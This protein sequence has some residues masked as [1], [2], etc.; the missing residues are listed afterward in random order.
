MKDLWKRLSSVSLAA[1]LTLQLNGKAFALDAADAAAAAAETPPQIV[2]PALPPAGTSFEGLPSSVDPAPAQGETPAV[3]TADAVPTADAP[4]EKLSTAPD[5]APAQSENQT[6]AIQRVSLPADPDGTQSSNASE[7]P[8]LTDSSVGAGSPKDPDSTPQ[9][10]SIPVTLFAV[11]AKSVVQ[12]NA[13]GA[14]EQGQGQPS[15]P[16]AQQPDDQELPDTQAPALSVAGEAVDLSANSSGSGWKYDAQD[17]SLVLINFDGSAQSITTEASDI[18]I[19]AAGLNRLEKLSVDG[20][21]HLIGTGI[22]LVD[23]IEMPEGKS[24]SLQPNQEIYGE[25]GGSVAV[26]LKQEDGSYKLINR[27][28]T[29]ILDEEY[30]LPE[31][32]TLVMPEGTELKLQSLAIGELLVEE[33]PVQIEYSTTSESKVESSLLATQAERRDAQLD[34]GIVEFSSTAAQLTIPETAKLIVQQAAKLV[35]KS[36]SELHSGILVPKLTVAGMLEL[37]GSVTGGDI[38]LAGENSFSGEGVIENARIDVLADQTLISAADSRIVLSGGTETETL[39]LSGENTLH[40]SGNAGVGTLELNGSSVNAESFSTLEESGHP[41]ALTLDTIIGNGT[42]S[43]RNGNIKVGANSSDGNVQ[44]IVTTGGTLVRNAGTD[45]EELFVV[46]PSGLIPVSGSGAEYSNGHY[47]FPVVAVH[48]SGTRNVDWSV[49]EYI[50]PEGTDPETVYSFGSGWTTISLKQLQE[51]LLPSTGPQ[52]WIEIYY[53]DGSGKPQKMVLTAEDQLDGKTIDAS[54]ISLIRAVAVTYVVNGSGGGSSTITDT[55]FTGSGVLGVGAGSVTG[56]SSTSILSG[57]GITKPA[58][59]NPGT[60]NPGN[61]NSGT[62]NPGTN[63]PG[64]NNPGTDNP[65]ANNPGTDN[66]GAD[67]TGNENADGNDSAA[68]GQDVVGAESGTSLQIW[69]DQPKAD[70]PFVLHMEEDGQA[71]EKPEGSISVHL[72]FRPAPELLGKKLYV[73]FRDRGGKLR[74]FSARYDAA[75]G[76][77]LFETELLGEFVV[78]APSYSAPEFSDRFYE[79]LAEMDEV[80]SLF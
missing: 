71:C 63:N 70:A 72:P 56:G 35:L 69:V 49:T 4:T 61:G 73:V 38:V 59:N 2:Q 8:G 47:S 3:Q 43:Y 30:T 55:S 80:Q 65:G 37:N 21:I 41:G 52:K 32:V 20:D 7:T 16:D 58:P 26:F 67:N 33:V 64:T 68:Q 74:A 75:S 57:T 10:D 24:L 19:K 45:S 78:V 66:T 11:Q 44:E 15:D 53:S 12:Q 1:L 27:A 39:A 5:P 77:L 13:Q 79:I 17:K 60:D 42:I 22:L 34:P 9:E 50:S 31:G 51:A 23:E 76:E 28:V 36:I 25:N 40:F 18:T 46:G 54:C 48:V 62:D 6:P 29:G 14:D